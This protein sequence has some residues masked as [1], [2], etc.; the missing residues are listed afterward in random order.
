MKSLLVIT[1]SSIDDG[2]PRSSSIFLLMC[3][4]SLDRFF[5][6]MT[7]PF[8]RLL[9]TTPSRNWIK[10]VR[11][12]TYES[13]ANFSSSKLMHLKNTLRF[14]PL[15]R[16]TTFIR[17]QISLTLALSPQVSSIMIVSRCCKASSTFESIVPRA[18]FPSGLFPAFRYF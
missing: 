3:D 12:M 14:N 4:D 2:F 7:L 5:F 1:S 17:L 15:S 13:S 6:T 16:P 9:Y 8:V 18:A 10:S 11:L